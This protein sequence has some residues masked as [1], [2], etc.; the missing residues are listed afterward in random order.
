MREPRRVEEV[1]ENSG[2]LSDSGISVVDKS[3]GYAC[4]RN[5]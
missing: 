4:K 1:Y 3:M 2:K 5:S